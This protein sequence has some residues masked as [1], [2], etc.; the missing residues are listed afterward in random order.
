M[1]FPHFRWCQQRA[2]GLS[3][4]T[5]N[6]EV[7]VSIPYNVNPN[8]ASDRYMKESRVFSGYHHDPRLSI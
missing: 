8:A 1:G 4:A 7:P 5:D 3:H 2:M 6:D